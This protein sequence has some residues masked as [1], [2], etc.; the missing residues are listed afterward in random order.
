MDNAGTFDLLAPKL[1]DLFPGRGMVFLSLDF[2]GHGWSSHREDKLYPF[3]EYAFEVIDVVRQLGW[4]KFVI[5]GHSMGGQ[6][7]VVVSSLLPNAVS[8]LVL[9]DIVTPSYRKASQTVEML[10]KSLQTRNQRYNKKH[11]IYPSR[12]SAFD[13]SKQFNSCIEDVSIHLLHRRGLMTGGGGD[14]GFETTKGFC[15]T[16]DSS[17]SMAFTAAERLSEEQALDVIKSV[18]AN[19]LILWGKGPKIWA[20]DEVALFGMSKNYPLSTLK[21]IQNGGHHLHLDPSS[22]DLVVSEIFDFLRDV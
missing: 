13:R 16:Y 6:I 7:G 17:F 4:E 15:W 3:S 12:R 19:V 10:S 21:L 8:R 9:L 18:K 1:M 20:F 11:A 22:V 2:V 5:L 14:D